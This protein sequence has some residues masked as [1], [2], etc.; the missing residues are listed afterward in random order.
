MVAIW[1]ASEEPMPRVPTHVLKGLPS[2]LS[3]SEKMEPG[4]ETED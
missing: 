3:L 4:W 2:R 1:W